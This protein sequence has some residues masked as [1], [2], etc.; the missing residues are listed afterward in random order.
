MDTVESTF[1]Y[2]NHSFRSLDYTFKLFQLIFKSKFT[3]AWTKAEAIVLN[4]FTPYAMQNLY[5]D[6]EKCKFLSI[7]ADASN[8]K[9]TKLFP[10]LARYIDWR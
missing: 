7:L 10:I 5:T 4:V 6:L 8:Y 1:A 9:E 2:Y 3:C